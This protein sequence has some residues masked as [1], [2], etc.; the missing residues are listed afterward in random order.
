M[1]LSY[2][3]V[4]VLLGSKDF[5]IDC[6]E[7]E[8]KETTCQHYYHCHY[9][10]NPN[11]KIIILESLRIGGGGGVVHII[12]LKISHHHIIPTTGQ[13]HLRRLLAAAA[14]Q[15]REWILAND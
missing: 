10:R 14:A 8:Q 1:K 11:W 3:H 2:R 13:A 15:P 4:I 7:R 12:I 5:T 9:P 6:S